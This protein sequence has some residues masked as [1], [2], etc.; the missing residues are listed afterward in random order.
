MAAAVAQRPMLLGEQHHGRRGKHR[1]SAAA[2]AE[3]VTEATVGQL[4]ALPEHGSLLF[5]QTR[6]Q[7][8]P[9]PLAGPVRS[10]SDHDNDTQALLGIE[11]VDSHE[12]EHDDTKPQHTRAAPL[13][14]LPLLLVGLLFILYAALLQEAATRF[15]LW[16]YEHG[17]LTGPEDWRL[18]ARAGRESRLQAL[19]TAVQRG[20][21]TS[22]RGCFLLV[23]GA[24]PSSAPHTAVVPMDADN[25]R[26]CVRER[27]PELHPQALLGSYTLD[28]KE[29]LAD[30]PLDQ[31]TYAM[32]Q[33]DIGSIH[34]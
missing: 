29:L 2:S 31:L 16:F 19:R 3:S 22:H 32:G 4:Q 5:C 15:E 20:D 12:E 26:E 33:C 6:T 27:F 9:Q 18:V 10:E 1:A 14:W 28:G 8:E 25:W 34:C 11:C 24:N 13:P 17:T 23:L 21:T 7:T 30:F